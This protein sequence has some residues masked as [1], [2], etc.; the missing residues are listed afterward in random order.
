MNTHD[1]YFK[2]RQQIEEAGIASC[3][4]CTKTFSSV[5]IHE[6]CDDGQTAICPYCGIDAVLA[7]THSLE[8]LEQLHKRWF[9][10]IY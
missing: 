9:K 2:N 3:F 5:K 1:P 6:W 4:C 10:R 8:L 7:G